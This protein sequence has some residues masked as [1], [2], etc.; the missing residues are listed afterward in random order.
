[1]TA[2]NLTKSLGQIFGSEGGYSKDRNDPGNWTGGSVGNGKMLGTK[3]GI[4][5][6]TYPKLDI[7]NLTLEQ[8]TE[9]YR[10][11][12]ASKVRFD[13]LPS[14]LDHAMLDFAINSGPRRAIE[15]LQRVLGVPDDGVFGQ[16]TLGEAR[17]ADPEATIKA[18][19]RDRLVYLKKL[20]TWPRYKNG[21][22][23]RVNAVQKFALSLAQ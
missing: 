7:K 6:N 5:A 12:Y 16:V 23:T 22:T 9:I 2:A 19:C 10:R 1:M 14:G 13:D 15:F 18:L 3:F 20:R 21:W 17:G 8:A 11:D 4:A